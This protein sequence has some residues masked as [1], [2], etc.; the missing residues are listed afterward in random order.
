MT[1][2]PA[3]FLLAMGL[4]GSQC[5][6]HAQQQQETKLEIEPLRPEGGG[7][8]TDLTTGFTVATNGVLV[9]YGEAVLTAESA[10]IDPS[11]G[12]VTA[13]GHVRIQQGEQ[14]WASEHVRY[15]YKTHQMEAEQFRTGETPVF[16]AGAG[17]HADIT[18][19][20][21]TATNALVTT[22]DVAQPAFKVRAR[23]IEIIPG[24]RI[25]AYG[26]TLYVGQ[27][28]TFYFPYYSRSIG[29]HSNHF[30]FTPGYRSLFGPFLLGNY[31]WYYTDELDG[32]FHLDYRLKRGPGVGPDFNYHLGKWGEGTLKYYYTHDNDPTADQLGVPISEN[33]QR[34]Y[35][36]YQANPATNLYLKA[37][38]RYESDLA[39]V[40]DFFESDYRRDPQPSS[41]FEANK[42]WNNFSVDA[43]AQ[44]RL[45]D[46]LETVERLPD[47]RVTGYRQQLGGS[48]L[49]YESE[50]SA[51]YYR[52]LFPDSLGTNGP[53]TGFNYEAGRGDTYH[54][55]LLPLTLFGWLNLTPRVGG[56]GTYYTE[57]SGPGATT[58]EQSRG[59]FNTG[60]EVSFKAYRLW[61]GVRSPFFDVDGLRHIFEPSANYV[62]VPAPTTAPNQLPQFDY[63][64]PSLR[65]LPNE[66]P[67]YNAIDSI[68]SQNVIRWGVRNKLQTKRDGQV[69]N[70]VNWDVYTDW[71]LKPRADQTTFSDLYS[72]LTLRPGSW[73][74]LESLVR[75]DINGGDWRMAFDTITIQP[76][77][78]LSWRI[79]Q[80]YLRDDLT[81]SPTALGVGN[82]VYT[83][84]LYYRLNENW[85][86]RMNH[87]F[88]ARDGRLR[89][90]SYTIYRDLR[91]WTAALSFLKRNNPTGPEDYTVAF[92]FSLKAYPHYP[93]GSDVGAPYSL[94]GM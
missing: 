55:V 13:D 52:R 15:N 59:V 23:R 69:V 44:P 93:L 45:N 9:K 50:T 67:D 2:L 21:Y 66:F 58:D 28:P 54:Q 8:V 41:F 1:R 16:A 72:D 29:E 37:L 81:P 86:F 92:T 25:R 7:L 83:S 11:T 49:Y 84:S 32:V 42:F 76:S 62:Y 46:F 33:R 63:E 77:P 18:N 22:D 19:R 40:R 91:S 30:N 31:T 36:A 64:L 48:P 78:A 74:T 10:T 47:I 70:L 38:A 51:G 14:L 87:Y 56:R 60:A 6:L 4:L 20:I 53:P 89:E 68:D 73:L 88:D 75:Y 80:Y 3:I 26:A 85:G 24:K 61:P 94:L 27:V 79:G 57:A 82:N 5:P 39:V 34:V 35:F 12:Q 90:Q 71:R 17:L 43:Y 65:Q